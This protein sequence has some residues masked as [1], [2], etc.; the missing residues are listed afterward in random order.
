MNRSHPDHLD[1]LLGRLP[2]PSVLSA[3]RVAALRTRI[4]ERTQPRGAPARAGIRLRPWIFAAVVMLLAAAAIASYLLG[5]ASG[6]SN[7]APPV[8]ELAP[9]PVEPMPDRVKAQDAAPPRLATAPPTQATPVSPSRAAR[10]SSASAAS[11]ATTDIGESQLAIESRLVGAALRQLRAER[12]GRGALGMLDAYAARFPRGALTAEARAARIEALLAVGDKAAALALLDRAAATPEHVVLRGEL[13][14]GAGRLVDA[15]ADF[16][17]ALIG[18]T[19]A[20]EQRALYGRAACRIAAGDH[21]GARHDL[22]TYLHRF[23]KGRSANAARG[24]L[25]QL[26]VKGSGSARP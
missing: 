18:T 7:L 9:P 17:S 6:P 3:A 13:R 11:V 21:A 12:D 15:R 23:P 22:E 2:A 8:P 25:E 14:F 1:A 19:D 5:V 10:A 26:S 24:M 16:E 20:I 4:D